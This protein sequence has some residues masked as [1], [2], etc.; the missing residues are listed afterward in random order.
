M[1]WLLESGRLRKSLGE[2]KRERA[3]KEICEFQNYAKGFHG[4]LRKDDLETLR[5]V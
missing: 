3:S 2:L 4:A 1:T 5:L